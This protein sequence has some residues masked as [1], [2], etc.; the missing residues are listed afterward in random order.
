MIPRKK[1]TKTKKFSKLIKNKNCLII[2]I[3][4]SEFLYDV[5]LALGIH[6]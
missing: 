1:K 3:L 5:G 4:Y 2:I 6:I